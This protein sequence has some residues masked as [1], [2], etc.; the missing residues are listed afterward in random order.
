MVLLEAPSIVP[1]PVG[2]VG[3]LLTWQRTAGMALVRR[4]VVEVC[5]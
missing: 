2:L 4:V 1:V 3:R 5:C